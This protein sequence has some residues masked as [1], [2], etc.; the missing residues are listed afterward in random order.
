MDK[1][2]IDLDDFLKMGKLGTDM[3]KAYEKLVGSTFNKII[4]FLIIINIV[5]LNYIFFNL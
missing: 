4:I 2:K 3:I 5:G 1:K